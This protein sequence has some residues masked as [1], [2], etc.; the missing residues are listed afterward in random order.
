MCFRIISASATQSEVS[1]L[2]K[3]KNW[4]KLG[5]KSLMK[6]F[7]CK[8]PQVFYLNFPAPSLNY[9][10][11]QWSVFRHKLCIWDERRGSWADL[12]CTLLVNFPNNL[13]MKY[14]KLPLV[15]SDG[16]KL[17][18]DSWMTSMSSIVTFFELIKSLNS[19]INA[20]G[21]NKSDWRLISG[22]EKE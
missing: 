17:N 14:L 12:K 22:T 3:G 8:W 1:M 21:S 7:T 9:L 20:W 15:R 16:W 5:Q 11:S 2:I 6:S 10:P 13:H 4:S 19:T 18:W